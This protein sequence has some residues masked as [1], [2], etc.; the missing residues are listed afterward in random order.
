MRRSWF[1]TFHCLL[2]CM[3]F[4]TCHAGYVK[5]SNSGKALPATAPL[6]SGP[7]EWACTY[8]S[9]TKLIWEVKTSSGFR[10]VAWEYTWYDT[11]A[12]TNFGMVGVENGANSNHCDK[13][14]HCNTLDYRTRVNTQTLCGASDWRLPN[15]SELS[16]LVFCSPG[17]YNTLSAGVIGSI[18]TAGNVQ[19]PTID[20]SYFP[21]TASN[22]YWTDTTKS[23][24]TDY[25]WF[26]NFA[27]G[28]ND[29]APKTYSNPVRLVRSGASFETTTNAA[30]I[31]AFT[32]TPQSGP[33]PLTVNLDASTA[34]DSD[35]NIT[36][37]VWSSSDGQANSGKLASLVFNTAGTFN[38]TLTV[39]DN[40][41]ATGTKTQ[42]VTVSAKTNL[43]PIA[44]FSALPT[45]GNI[46]L[47]VAL[48]ASS[49]SDPEGSIK[50]YAWTSSDGQTSNTKLSNFVFNT[51]GSFSITLTVTDDQ[52]VSS[53]KTI[54]VTANNQQNVAPTAAFNISPQSGTAP[55]VVNV[56]AGSSRDA[57]G[58]ISSYFWTSTD[59]QSASGVTASFKFNTA[60]A[61]GIT[62]TVTDNKGATSSKTSSV[63]VTEKNNIPPVAAF[64]L[65]PTTGT[66]PLSVN[67]DASSA[68]DAD[69]NITDY[70]WSS[71]DGQSAT[72][73]NSS[74]TF[75][76]AGTYSISLTVTDD[77]R[78]SNTKTV[79]LTV[80]KPTGVGYI[81]GQV[82]DACTGEA[83]S[84]ADINFDGPDPKTAQSNKI[85]TYTSKLAVGAYAVKVSADNY[86]ARSLNITVGQNTTRYADFSLLP[87]S[88]KCAGTDEQAS[89][90]KAIILAGGGPFVLGQVNHIWSATQE[91]TDKAYRS[92]IKQGFTT[93]QIQY[94]TADKQDLN[95]RVDGLAAI[96]GI[97]TKDALQQ[98]IIQWAAD[99]D[100]V[101]IYVVSH[102]DKQTI[103]INETTLLTASE[104]KQ[105]LDSLQ[106]KIKGRVTVIVEACY[107]GSFIT[108]LAN[109]K[110]KRY[111]ITSSGADQTA[112]VSANGAKSFSYF[113]WD[114]VIFSGELREAYRKAR[115]ATGAQVV[116]DGQAQKAV[117]DANGDGV[118]TTD[119]YAALQHYCFGACNRRAGLAPD[120]IA[121]TP[122][123]TLNGQL[124]AQLMVQAN[125][126]SPLKKAWVTIQR[127]DFKFPTTTA[128][129][130]LP[131]VDLT[132]AGDICQGSYDNFNVN[133]NYRLSFYVQNSSDEISLP[134]TVELKQSGV[135]ASASQ[136]DIIYQP[137]NGLLSIQDVE[138]SG[139]HFWVELQDRTLGQYTFTIKD[140][141]PLSKS[142]SATPASYANGL[143]SLPRLYL[144]NSQ[145]NY[146]IQLQDLGNLTFKPKLESLESVQ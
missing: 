104:F 100:D 140:Y 138:V 133:G 110:F 105:W 9:N 54:T 15:N 52:N 118:E 68:T 3:V 37:Y 10:S 131:Q 30:P 66:A 90:Y 120:I 123:D 124:Q 18:C 111:V 5:V 48:D 69:G 72:G 1:N 76:R 39:T 41:G 65:S 77:K 57:D 73:K 67:L 128:I 114:E 145:Q 136:A 53:S 70:A 125:T 95:R 109:N 81:D 137:R 99:V 141:F 21:N 146:K 132:C 113:F 107:S 139:Q 135:D 130:G 88:G 59:G 14:D 121:V 126:S 19:A 46:P 47:N 78:A 64:T 117:V 122:Q 27:N 108:P 36:N 61:Y 17:G 75:S 2:L 43:P 134:R 50:S 87:S 92:F 22:L 101:V 89:S 51:A 62:L 74:L 28:S 97:A 12:S 44:A 24:L 56:D 11:N 129:N 13:T 96:N 142:I 16:T 127:P 58:T 103:L 94:F 93:Q 115:Q 119:D 40:L 82:Y 23:D 143:L 35:G 60:G 33:A 8:D 98:A 63:S 49:A 31:A 102:G 71:S 144:Y 45:S 4:A 26:T 84:Y 86:Q 80:N 32:L 85:G 91:L 42:T 83:L 55:L 20:T 106:S 6:G 25:A 79:S 38:I 116:V 34:T 29:A 7:N 112:V